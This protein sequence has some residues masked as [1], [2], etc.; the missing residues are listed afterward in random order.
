[1]CESVFT[2]SEFLHLVIIYLVTCKLHLYRVFQ[3]VFSSQSDAERLG[4]SMARRETAHHRHSQLHTDQ[5][6]KCRKH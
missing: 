4:I 1:M 3:G 5:S 6:G 2:S